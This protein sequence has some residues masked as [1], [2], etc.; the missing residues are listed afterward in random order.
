MTDL[1]K[2]IKARFQIKDPFFKAFQIPINANK[3]NP[4]S[5]LEFYHGIPCFENIADI[6]MGTAG[7]GRAVK[8]VH[9][10]D[11]IFRASDETRKVWRPN[12]DTKIFHGTI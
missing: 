5:L 9:A 10:D 4:P 6:I 11:N 12:F 2:Q 8:K 3:S 1:V 7:I